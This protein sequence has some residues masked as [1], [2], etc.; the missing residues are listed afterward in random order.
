MTDASGAVPDSPSPPASSGH[1]DVRPDLERT[2]VPV[3]AALESVSEGFILLDR[4]WR[5]IFANPAAEGFMRQARADVLGKTLWECFPEALSRRFGLEYHRAVADNVPV[6]FEEFYPEPLNAW[7]EVRAYPSPEGLSIFFRDISRRR[8]TDE[9][10]RQSEERYRALFERMSEG[11]ALHEII[12]RN[13]APCDYRFLDVNPAFE[14]LTGLKRAEVVGRLMSEVLPGDDPHWVTAYGAVALSGEAIRFDHFSTVLN[15]HYRVFAFRPAPRQFAV[16]F[17]DITE[18]RN[19]EEALRVNL[20]K[21]SVLFDA[22][23]LGISVTDTAGNVREINRRASLLLGTTPGEVIGQKVGTTRWR[24]IRPDG[25]VMPPDEFA[26]VRAMREK[27]VIEDVETGI[28]RPGEDVIW[29]SVT[30]APIPLEGYG[31]V[32]TYGDISRRRQAEIRLAE[33]HRQT[34]E[35]QARLE[36]AMETVPVG[37]AILDAT[38]G[39]VRVNAEFERIWGVGRPHARS[40]ADYGHYRAR[41]I[42]TGREVQPDDWASARAL[43]TGESVIGQLLEIE[44]FDGGR[45]IVLNSAAP[46]LDEQRA[47]AG[48]AVAIEDVSRLIEVERALARSEEALRAANADLE[49]ANA[50]LRRSNET[51]EARV[52]ERT[53]DLALRASQ[54]EALALDRTRAEERERQKI[55]RVVHDHLQQLLSVAR[56]NLGVALARARERTLRQ[57]L[58]AID[59]LIGESVDITR[60]ISS[61]LSPAIVHRSTLGRAIRWLGQWFENRFGLRVVVDADD[62]LDVDEEV[63]V[64]LF[65]AARELLFNV[66]KH[67]RV[68]EAS[69]LA[70]QPCD[71]RVRVVVCDEGAGFE[72]AIL[73]AWDGARGSFGLFSLREHLELLGGRL[74]VESAPGRGTTVTIVGPAPRPLDD[75][76]PRPEVPPTAAARRAAGSV[77]ARRARQAPTRPLNPRARQRASRKAR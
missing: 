9:A 70:S 47:A 11:F 15:R 7:F 10:L 76:A 25:S 56:M 60:A 8:A 13:G 67:A 5:F 21:Y 75:G 26:S 12:C 59:G 37:L 41:W 38:G 23:P 1:D 31:V 40:I 22:F 52:A 16:L 36:A 14:A 61:D 43:R 55:A 18:H 65:R 4:E 53:A 71:G 50:G 34:V 42:D 49:A 32:I 64:M 45:T 69:M 74:D 2:P 72:P 44:R 27:R 46:I 68:T 51:L 62:D 30:A 17:H 19:L 58:R 24:I 57:S 35:A 6:Q 20:T 73:R 33:T 77:K 28:A 54:I 48:C 66:V 39:I 29:V 63:R 3:T